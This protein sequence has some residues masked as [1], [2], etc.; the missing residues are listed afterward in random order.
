M[1]QLDQTKY[2]RTPLYDNH[3]NRKA[4]LIPFNNYSLPVWFS[5]IK[6]EHQAVRES[7]GIFDISHMGVLSISGD[8]AFSDLQCLSCNDIKKSHSGKMI[9]SMLLNE[10]GGVLD[11]V[12]V[13]FLRQPTVTSANLINTYIMVTNAANTEK[14]INWI[15]KFKQPT[16]TLTQLNT[17]YSLIALQGP[18]VSQIYNR[19]FS[20]ADLIVPFSVQS[21]YLKGLDIDTLI[22]G[23]GYTGETGVEILIPNSHVGTIWNELIEFGATPC[24]LGA[25][26]TLRLEKGFPLYGQELS[27][28]INPL[29]TR[30]PWVVD[31]NHDFIGKTALQQMTTPRMKTV[32]LKMESRQI[33]RAGDIITS[34]GQVTS[35]TLSPSLNIPIAMAIVPIESASIGNTLTIQSRGKH[36][37]ARVCKV[38][39]TV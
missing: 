16:T 9:Y 12:M 22:M 8:T 18:K 15:S 7:A 26:D 4:K 23:T 37:S 35:G 20:T 25:R 31:W 6:A 3:I 24:G 11:D 14:I 5:S 32:G 10:S 34:G 17:A 28:H 27:T 19:V 1:T 33:A 29:M 39:F 38:P 30:Y 21:R 2:R 13:G 36:I